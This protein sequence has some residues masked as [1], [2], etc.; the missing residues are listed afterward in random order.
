LTVLIALLADIHANR[1][2]FA[3]CVAAAQERGAE[4]FIFLGDYVGYGGDPEATTETVMAM[5]ERGAVAVRGNHDHAVS[6][7]H[8]R[9]NIEA[10]VAIEWTR[11][12]LGQAHRDFLATLPLTLNDS[13]RLYVHAEASHP[14]HW[15]YVTGTIEA[16]AS[17][18]A[19]PAQITFCGHVHRPALYSMSRTGKMSAFTPVSDVSIHLIPGRRWLAVLGAVGQPRDGNPAAVYAL[20]DTT[21][22]TLTYSRVPYDIE[23]AAAQIRKHRLPAALADRLFKGR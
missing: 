11:G 3:A 8:E 18:A 23:S 15:I 1:Q 4:R 5:V 21:V 20:F 12:V 14:A 10:R 13:D 9:M 16:S 17:I 6:D 19:T 22:R 2:A 7:A